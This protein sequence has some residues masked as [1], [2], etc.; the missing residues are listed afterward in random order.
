MVSVWCT[1]GCGAASAEPLD[2][3]HAHAAVVVRTFPEAGL[4]VLAVDASVLADAPEPFSFLPVDEVSF[5]ELPACQS[6][7][8]SFLTAEMIP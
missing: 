6:L 4:V 3:L 7:F 1:V 5:D 2:D 8:Q